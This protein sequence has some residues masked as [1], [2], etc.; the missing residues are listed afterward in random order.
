MAAGYR[1]C[2]ICGKEYE[3]C[4]TERSNTIFRWQD[5]ACS[6]EHAAEYFHAIAVSRGEVEPD[7]PVAIELPSDDEDDLDDEFEEDFDDD[8]E[9]LDN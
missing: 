4:T 9:E 1:K 8:E 2:K 3:Y 6:P 7:E 5:V